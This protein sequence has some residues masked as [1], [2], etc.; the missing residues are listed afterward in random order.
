MAIIPNFKL[1]A[2]GTDLLN[3]VIAEQK[4]LKFTKF[5]IGDGSF[6]GDIKTLQTLVSKFKEFAVIETNV[7]GDGQTNIKGYFDNKGFLTSKRLREFGVY[8]QIGDEILT[9]VLFSYTNAGDTA[10]LIP[11]ESENFFSRTLSVINKTD[12]VD[13]ITF[14]VSLI[15]CKRDFNTVAELKAADWLVAGDKVNLWG[16]LTLGD[17]KKTSKIITTENVGIPLLNGLYAKDYTSFLQDGGY[18]KDA[19][20]L[21]RDI[22]SNSGLLED[23]EIEYIQDAG[24]KKNG[25]CYKDKNQQG[26]FK[27][28]KDYAG[29][30]ND[31]NYFYKFDNNELLGKLQNLTQFNEAVIQ[32]GEYYDVEYSENKLFNM[33]LIKII[34]KKTIP[35]GF[36]AKVSGLPNNYKQTEFVVAGNFNTTRSFRYSNGAVVSFGSQE[37]LNPSFYGSCILFKK[38]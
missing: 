38:D 3:R 27:C 9:E 28:F 2:R 37:D 32:I 22:V 14:N 31:A 33:M 6:T 20:R 1:T 36:E 26:I 21:N 29:T 13:N 7:L 10:D 16:N 15:N 24:T 19:A 12:D 4:T 17:V 23:L 11:A 30:S 25:Y 35:G 34:P 5:E 18:K 8:A